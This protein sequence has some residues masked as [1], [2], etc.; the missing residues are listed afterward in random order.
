MIT[1]ADTIWSC[2]L[3]GSP[4]RRLIAANRRD[5]IVTRYETLEQLLAYCQLSAAPVGELVLHIFG[6]ATPE[7][8][9][10]SDRISAALQITEHLQDVAE[11]YRQG[12]VYLPQE[13]LTRFGCPDESLERGLPHELISFEVVRERQ[14]LVQGAPLVRSLPLLPR[15]AVAGFVAGGRAALARLEHDGLRTDH[16]RISIIDMAKAMVGR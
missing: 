3:P 5:Q 13:D 2:R 7:R 14:L 1:L 12:R 6:K 9:Q 4:F 15:I 8:I 16:R 11:D 10:L